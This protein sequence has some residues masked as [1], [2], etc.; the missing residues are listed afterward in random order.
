MK[1]IEN[2]LSNIRD[3]VKIAAHLHHAGLIPHKELMAAYRAE[4]V[5]LH[6]SNRDYVPFDRTQFTPPSP[7]Y[8][9]F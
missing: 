4:N 6:Y 7:L 8:V 2:H 5:A 9:G 1:A 3:S